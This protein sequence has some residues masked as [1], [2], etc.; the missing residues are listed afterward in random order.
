MTI[1]TIK[2]FLSLSLVTF[3]IFADSGSVLNELLTKLMSS[4]FLASSTSFGLEVVEVVLIVIGLV[5]DNC[6]SLSVE[7]IWIY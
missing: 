2:Y 3:S 7:P 1:T 6:L 5:D 4:F